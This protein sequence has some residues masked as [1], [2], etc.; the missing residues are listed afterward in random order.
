[1]TQS[2]KRRLSPVFVG[3]FIT[4][5][6]VGCLLCSL[7]AVLMLS[8]ATLIKRPA[9]ETRFQANQQ[10]SLVWKPSDG[11][12]FAALPGRVR[13]PSDDSPY[14]AFE[15]RWDGEGFRVPAVEYQTYPIAVFGDSFT[16]GFSVGVPYPDRLAEYLGVGVRN[17]GYR[18]YGPVEVGRTAA[19]FADQETRQWVIWGFFSGNDIGDT[20]RPSLVELSPWGVWSAFLGQ[21]APPAPTATPRLDSAGQP[22]YDFPMPVIIGGNFFELAFVPYY[23]YWQQ[24]PEGGFEASQNFEVVKATL[25]TL[26]ATG[27]A[28]AC[29]ALVFIPTKEQLYFPYIHPG[30]RQ[31]LRAVNQRP[32]LDKDRRLGYVEA[33]ISEADE[34]EFLQS[35]YGQRDA[36]RHLVES[37]TGWVFIDLLPAFEAAVSSGELLYYPYDTHWNQAGHD[38]AA[39]VIADSLGHV[40]T[41]CEG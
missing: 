7:T 23:W 41:P 3:V 36:M 5:L 34:A 30:A 37:Q 33:P 19:R 27:G 13:P 2:S 6:S 35:L 1:M 9:Y 16:E 15:L 11:D 32:Q 38:L 21:S 20:M 8:P 22:Q 26:S 18:A 40:T 12:V 14:A 31:Y 25:S 28:E 29:H 39:Q 10:M 24:A 17:Y 4:L